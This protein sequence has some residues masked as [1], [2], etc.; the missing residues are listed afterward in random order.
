MPALQ[1][2]VTAPELPQAFDYLRWLVMR[3]GLGYGDLGNSL[4]DLK[5]TF[6]SLFLDT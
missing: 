3:L 4:A 1:A 5:G 2:D 6:R